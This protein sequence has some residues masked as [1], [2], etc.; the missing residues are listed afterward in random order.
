M[1]LVMDMSL[2]TFRQLLRLVISQ[3]Q[4]LYIRMRPSSTFLQA[5]FDEGSRG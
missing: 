1:T 3:F 5:A 2:R 4:I